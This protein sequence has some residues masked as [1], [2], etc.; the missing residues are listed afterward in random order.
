MSEA[1]IQLVTDATRQLTAVIVPIAL[2]KEIA[3][4]RETA[5]L[6]KSGT[7]RQPLLQAVER[8]AECPWKMPR[9]NWGC[10][11]NVESPAWCGARGSPSI[12]R[13]I[14]FTSLESSSNYTAT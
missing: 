8:G 9:R 12:N 4:Q 14:P 13:L 3:S 7:M 10:A 6:L 11:H 2:W 1:D 5:Y